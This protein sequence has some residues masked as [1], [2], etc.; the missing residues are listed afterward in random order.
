MRCEVARTPIPSRDKSMSILLAR[1]LCLA[2]LMVVPACGAAGPVAPELPAAAVQQAPEPPPGPEPPLPPAVHVPRVPVCTSAAP[3]PRPEPARQVIQSGHLFAA[4]EVAM[5]RSGLLASASQHDGTLRVWDVARRALLGAQRVET[6]GLSMAWNDPEPTLTLTYSGMYTRSTV[7]DAAGKV[8]GETRRPGFAWPVRTASGTLP[9]ALAAPDEE[10]K[11]H[12]L[13]LT[14]PGG[15]GSV[16]LARPK[17]LFLVEGSAVLARK[18]KTLLARSGSNLFVWTLAGAGVRPARMVTLT[19]DAGVRL[20]AFE[21]GPDLDFVTIATQANS[22]P[23]VTRVSLVPIASSSAKPGKPADLMTADDVNGL[24]VSPDG[25]R[26]VVGF[27]RGLAVFDTAT[28]KMAWSMR[29]HAWDTKGAS[30]AEG[31]SMPVFT[32]DGALLVAQQQAGPLTVLDAATGRLQGRM[33]EPVRQPSLVAWAGDTTLVA[34]SYGHVAAWDA[35]TGEI[36]RGFD[37]RDLH[38]VTL[39]PGGDLLVARRAPCASAALSAPQAALW[40]DRWTALAPPEAFA[41]RRVPDPQLGCT[42]KPGEPAAATSIP[43]PPPRGVLAAPRIVPGYATKIDL[44][45]HVAVVPSKPGFSAASDALLDLATGQ[46]APIDGLPLRN[47]T[48]MA[49]DVVLEGGWLFASVRER[50]KSVLRAWDVRTGKVVGSFDGFLAGLSA[51]GTYAALGQGASA[52]IVLLPSGAAVTT[53]S[54][55]GEAVERVGFA[56]GPDDFFVATQTVAAPHNALYRV[57][58]G[59]ATPLGFDPAGTPRGLVPQASGKRLAVLGVDGA[60]RLWDVPSRE[61]LATLLEF[62]DDE[63]LAFTP[64]GA[65]AGTAEVAQRVGWVF[66][67]PLEP[68]RF[69][70]FAEAFDRP[71]LVRRRLAG[72]PVDSTE[73]VSRPPHVEILAV[74]SSATARQATLRVRASAS[75]RVDEVRVFVEGRGVASAVVCA[76]EKELDL[77]VPLLGHTSRV[78]VLAYDERGFASNPVVVDVKDASPAGR[79]PDVWVVSVGVSKYPNLS[80]DYQLALA[81]EDAKGVVLAFDDQAGEGK[82]FAAAHAKLLLGPEAAPDRIAAA[83]RELAAMRPEDIA[84]VFFAGHG[85]KPDQQEMVF[86]TSQAAAT[87]ASAKANGVGWAVIGEALARAKGRVLVLLDACHSGHLT[88]DLVVPNNALADA[89]ASSGRAGVFVF[90]AAKGRQLSFEP[91]GDARALVLDAAT[92]PMVVPPSAGPAG[93]SPHGFFTGALLASLASEATDANRDGTIQLEE[94]VD[95]TTE[96]VMRATKGQQ[97]PWV[98]RHEILGDFG[99]AA[100]PTRRANGNPR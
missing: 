39:L 54:F 38:G 15:G 43:W 5:S 17:E 2:L 20:V 30:F 74:A 34:S 27:G 81:E 77:T 42:R 3:A 29:G 68:F 91:S 88:Q 61:L 79:R 36:A 40:L 65:Y 21:V 78:T 85:V 9:A 67:A 98:A 92:R 46:T 13:V 86:L 41:A 51:D 82:A 16:R 28:R 80:A 48:S 37:A 1:R 25:A 59:A 66:D 33:G 14:P 87:R 10:G 57:E 35:S 55:P 71:D 22:E 95:A 75:G 89:L 76:A 44:A 53:V 12:E 11:E 63:P 90:A 97:T 99:I 8:L 26:I 70:Q 84:V 69:E 31:F 94:L 52:A 19:E 32:P 50:G 73:R 4:T 58:K 49:N 60:I 24:A 23:G 18:G 93:A 64:R 72:E 6:F 100:S 62:D 96:R 83:L 47:A 45:H 56:S 7:V